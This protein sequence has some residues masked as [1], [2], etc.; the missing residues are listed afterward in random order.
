MN[1]VLFVRIS[2]ELE[3]AELDRRL[4]ERLPRF[5]DVPGLIQKIYGRD[6]ATGHVC[7]IYFFETEEALNNF[8]NSELARTIASAYEAAEVRPEAY[9]MLFPLYQDKGPF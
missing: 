2:T 8:R 4:H 7:G 1:T 3:P 9:E 5:R 6:N